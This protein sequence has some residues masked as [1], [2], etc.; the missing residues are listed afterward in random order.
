MKY[1][2]EMSGLGLGKLAV[3]SLTAALLT[4]AAFA[5]T[6]IKGQHVEPAFE[7]WRPNDDGTFN[8][9]FGYMN[10][11]WEEE[12]NVDIGDNNFFSPGDADRGQPTHFLPRRNRFTFEVTVP[13]DWGDRELVWTLNVNGVERKAYGTLVPDYLVDNMVI[14]SETGSLGAG[15]SSPES[16]LNVPPVVTVQG[17]NIRTV[18][19]GQPMEL[20]TLVADDGLPTPDDPVAD[21]IRF[22][23]FFGGPLAAALITEENVL[24]RRLMSPPAKPTVDKVNGLFLSW[25][26]YRG[27]GNVTFDPPMPKPWE[28][29]RTSA[30][31]PWGAL[32]MP[33][34]VPEDGMYNVEVTFDEP[35][36]YVLWGRADDGGLYHDGFITVNVTE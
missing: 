13:S 12:P 36:T 28:D 6:Y 7:G 24:Q 35:G 2:R 19:A 29:T 22:A 20:A 14:A 21:A 31:S 33:P 26:V 5:D 30:N 23:G 32:W 27:E 16:R 34:A 9:M 18:R 15:T 1:L 3:L 8:L 10:E 25:N 11:N 4:Q 17:D